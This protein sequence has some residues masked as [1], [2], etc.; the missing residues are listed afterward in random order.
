MLN[1]EGGNVVL[2]Q[3]G[4]AVAAATM[5]R[6]GP[7]PLGPSQ[8][9]P[10]SSPSS[11]D[12]GIGT[13]GSMGGDESFK[14]SEQGGFY[15]GDE[16]FSKKPD[17]Y[18]SSTLM[19][20]NEDD[21]TEDDFEEFARAVLFGN[22]GPSPPTSPPWALA[23]IAAAAAATKRSSTASG[24]GVSLTTLVK[25]PTFQTVLVLASYLIA[26]HHFHWRLAPG[27]HLSFLISISVVLAMLMAGPRL[28]T[29][30]CWA[31]VVGFVGIMICARALLLT[32]QELSDGL[33][34]TEKSLHGIGLFALVLGAWL[35]A[36]PEEYLGLKMRTLA[37]RSYSLLRVSGLLT[38]AYRT[39]RLATIAHIF[40]WVDVPFSLSV[41]ATVAIVQQSG[42]GG[43]VKMMKG[44][45]CRNSGAAAA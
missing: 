28:A 34:R 40:S 23:G 26:T 12:G 21:N 7:P 45:V 36:Q 35:G 42:A 1:L 39:G 25:S 8:P 37:M 20:E 32:P 41:L 24:R 3:A 5:P 10:G 9:G 33:D 13:I 38:M 4:Y 15:G 44:M 30:I 14:G 16:S 17:D 27:Y 43:E 11:S 29:R 19:N 2:Q 22:P 6:H 31:G 18:Q